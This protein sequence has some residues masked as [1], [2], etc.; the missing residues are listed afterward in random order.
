MWH[1][2]KNSY[3]LETNLNNYLLE[4]ESNNDVDVL[5]KK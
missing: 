3:I 5:Q 2:T 1:E 4:N